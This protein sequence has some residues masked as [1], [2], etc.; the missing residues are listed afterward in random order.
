LTKY[1]IQLINIAVYL[2]TLS[3]LCLMTVNTVFCG[4]QLSLCIVEGPSW[5]WSYGSWIYSYI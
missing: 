4:H 2:N 1:E 3:L 5:L